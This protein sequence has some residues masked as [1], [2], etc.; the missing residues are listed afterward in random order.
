MKNRFTSKLVGVNPRRSFVSAAL[1]GA[2]S[3]ASFQTMADDFT[4][5]E[6]IVTASKRAQTLQ[7]IP[8]AV[9][10]TSGEVIEKAQVQDLLDLQ[11]LVPSLKIIQAQ[12]SA[13]ADFYIRGFGNGANNPGIEPSV[14]VFIDGVYRSRPGSAISD[15]PRLERVEVLRG[16]QSTLFGKNASAG[17]VS[18]VTPVPSG[19]SGGFVSASVGNLNSVVVKGLYEGSFTDD[20]SFDI[21]GSYN[22]RDGF[23]E[24]KETG[25]DLNDRDRYGIRGQL[26]YTPTES[27]SL[28][29]QAD[30]DKIDEA[31]CS[32]V[33]VVSGPATGII[34]AVG[35]Q[36][37]PNDGGAT[38]VYQN[39]DPTNEV[40][41]YGLS[42]TG[43]YDFGSYTGTT[44][45]SYRNSDVRANQDVDFTSADLL[46]SDADAVDI[47]T[48]TAEV[49]FASNG[50]GALDWL[51]GAFY[52][53]E[54]IEQETDLI[55]GD[56]FRTA[57]DISLAVGG[58]PLT[59]S[60]AEAIASLANGSLFSAGTGTVE[61]NSLDNQSVSLFGQLDWHLSDDV[62]ATVGFNYTHDEKQFE[63]SQNLTDVR[64]L[65]DLTLF[66][67]APGV[68]LDDIVPLAVFTGAVPVPNAIEDDE[69][70]DED[71]T[72]TARIAWDVN[73]NINLYAT[74][75]TGFKASSVNLDRSSAPN[76]ADTAALAAAGSLPVNTIVGGR[77]ADP[78]ETTLYEVGFK[79]SFNQV[80]V[81]AAVFDQTI[82][83]F[84]ENA[85]LGTT[86]LLTNAGKQSVRGAEV[87]ITYSPTE[88]WLLSFSATYLDPLYDDF[89]TSPNGDL[90]G[91]RPSQISDFS[92]SMSAQY[93][94]DVGNWEAYVR[95]DYQYEDESALDNDPAGAAIPVSNEIK[96]LNMSLGFEN[97]YGYRVT[98]WGRNVLDEELI[99]DTFASPVQDGSFSAFRN[100]PRTYG[101]SL[102]KDF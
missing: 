62:T 57:I 24:N 10:V 11:S 84:Q 93:S 56:A 86:F 45:L 21:S 97:Q 59:L 61:T 50:G 96:L 15:L 36:L 72:Y 52:F 48:Y 67:V 43:E 75:A 82:K 37:V 53:D 60:D 44:I 88:A 28:R 17:V 42:F 63:I 27:L 4:L 19:E 66:P 30:Y 41:N 55:Y 49:R 8:I 81:N 5:E 16:P 68:T 94:F 6:I 34:N 77:F 29:L 3:L 85:F 70:S 54:S 73:E 90:S 13:N 95:G 102:R 9:S 39:F 46:A 91:E 32:A 51:V 1:S 14:G 7:E 100:E 38:K 18:V 76:A 58:S 71:V 87:D 89:E 101:I 12:T 80:S 22:E 78:E 92:Y 65:T 79:G 33:N 40:K 31:C 47:D 23:I 83:G 74:Y 69:T 98:L 26:Y 2:I 35:G 99:I 20:L 64:A 25:S